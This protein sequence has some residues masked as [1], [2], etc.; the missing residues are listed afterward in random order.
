MT[1]LP[2]S[3]RGRHAVDEQPPLDERTDDQEPTTAAAG[4]APLPPAAGQAPVRPRYAFG[5]APDDAGDDDVIGDSVMGD[6]VVRGAVVHEDE[7]EDVDY[8]PVT[9]ADV[10]GSPDPAPTAATSAAPAP[11]VETPVM[12]ADQG[13]ATTATPVPAPRA[14]GE[15]EPAARES[16]AADA[17]LDEPLLADGAALRA[18]WRRAQSDFVDDPRAAVSDAA[19][20]VEQTAQAIIDTVEQR[21]R[22]LRQQWQRG[23]ADDDQTAPAGEPSDTERLRQTMRRYRALFEQLCGR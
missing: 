7:D 3:S 23:Q 1:F 19:A 18:R 8:P 21:Q 2:H 11:A 17:G 13:I 9:V 5:Y 15:Y 12:E 16:V 10:P 4:E 14:G 22:L 20:L 6:S